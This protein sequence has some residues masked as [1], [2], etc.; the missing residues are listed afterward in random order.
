MERASLGNPIF[1]IALE[2]HSLDM[3]ELPY[4]YGGRPLCILIK[5][6]IPTGLNSDPLS[7]LLFFVINERNLSFWFR[8][9]LAIYISLL[10]TLKNVSRG[11]SCIAL[12]RY[13]FFSFDSAK[14]MN[15]PDSG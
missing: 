2:T 6:K 5:G 11:A 8:C 10:V 3:E 13:E 12:V 9:R 7:L 15:H 1:P 14:R 4:Q